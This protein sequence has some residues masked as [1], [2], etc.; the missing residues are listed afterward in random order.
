M[1]PVCTDTDIAARRLSHEQTLFAVGGLE[2]DWSA[3]WL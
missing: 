1:M 2:F 3:Q